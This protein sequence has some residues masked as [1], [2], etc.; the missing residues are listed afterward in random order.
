M[1]IN[2]DKKSGVFLTIIAFLI[3]ALFYVS[4]KNDDGM[5]GGI[6]H[7]MDSH[8]GNKMDNQMGS[9]TSNQSSNR[10][11][12]GADIMFLQM[13]IPHHQQAIDMSNLALTRSKN[14]ELLDLAKKIKSAQSAEIV[15][16]KAW[17]KDAGASE[18]MGHSMHDMGGMLSDAEMADL[19]A[20]S[21]TTFDK[22]WLNGMIGHH[23]GA[24]HMTNM[25]IDADNAELK[26]FGEGIIKV[27]TAE[28]AQMKE[29]L[30]KL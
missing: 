13:M 2:I 19:K 26:A 23:D 1:Q 21:G 6:S 30:K 5:M 12:T 11:Y 29:M 16:M 7:D 18:D 20:A 24:L 25:I 9:S 3:G 15:Q 17:L 10:K 8:M 27:Q 28:I 22:L 14:S 4:N